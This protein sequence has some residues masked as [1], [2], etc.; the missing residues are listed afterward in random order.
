MPKDKQKERNKVLFLR[1][2]GLFKNLVIWFSTIWS[3]VR[4]P[5]KHDVSRNVLLIL[6]A[7]VCHI[8]K[9]TLAILLKKQN[10]ILKV[11]N[12]KDILTF[13]RKCIKPEI[14]SSAK[15]KFSK[16][17][18]NL[19]PKTNQATTSF[20]QIVIC[21]FKNIACVKVLWQNFKS[22]HQESIA[23]RKTQRHLTLIGF[24]VKPAVGLIL[25]KLYSNWK[26][27][28]TPHL[29]RKIIILMWKPKFDRHEEGGTINK[30][31]KPCLL[32]AA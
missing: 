15:N 6:N 7:N 20:P 26:R 14:V 5:Q 22:W 19:E 29:G 18:K 10:W 17:V 4:Q 13:K 3:A 11:Q 8:N 16:N 1:S 21:C 24:I 27:F 12:Y 30:L 23:L 32:W 25:Q 2:S 9:N 31:E 28:L